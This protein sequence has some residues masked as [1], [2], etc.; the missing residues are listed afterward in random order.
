MNQN[1]PNQTFPPHKIR[2]RFPLV[3]NN[4]NGYM[5]PPNNYMLNQHPQYPPPFDPNMPYPNGN[6]NMIRTPYNMIRGPHFDQQAVAYANNNMYPNPLNQFPPNVLPPPQQTNTALLNQPGIPLTNPNINLNGNQLAQPPQNYP[7]T[8]PIING[9][10]TPGIMSEAEFYK[11]QERLRKERENDSSTTKDKNRK[12]DSKSR[13]NRSRSRRR[14]HSRSRTRTRS[15]SRSRSRLDH[16]NRHRS[17]SPRRRSRSSQRS[18]KSYHSRSYQSTRAN[19]KH[20]K[21]SKSDRS[22]I[23]TQARKRSRSRTRSRSRNRRY[24]RTRSPNRSKTSSSTNKINTNEAPT[25]PKT[26]PIN[27]NDNTIETN[28]KS[29]SR[30]PSISAQPK[31]VDDTFRIEQDNDQFS[32]NTPPPEILDL[33]SL[34]ESEELTDLNLNLFEEP[35]KSHFSENNDMES[36]DN[37]NDNDLVPPTPKVHGTDENFVLS[38]QLPQE[39]E[40]AVPKKRKKKKSSKEGSPS[41]TS[42]NSNNADESSEKK[43]SKHKSKSKKKHKSKHKSSDK[44]LN[45]L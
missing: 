44:S 28:T 42:L 35:P 30:S 23:A 14:S 29:V 3:N 1:F 18:P 19:H 20:H 2:N 9:P 7:L 31:S 41:E 22:P 15:R 10:N 36:I 45:L 24:S 4:N 8:Q 17:R 43:S 34:K 11:F 21:S 25:K 39:P 32:N 26:P 6:V 37:D 16:R 27:E 5:R 12:Y 40:E 13:R 33:F 38:P